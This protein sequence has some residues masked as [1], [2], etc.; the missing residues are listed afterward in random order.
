MLAD[1]SEMRLPQP[2]RGI[3][4][5]DI[6]SRAKRKMTQDDPVLKFVVA[7]PSR[8]IDEQTCGNDAEKNPLMFSLRTKLSILRAL[9]LKKKSPYYIQFYVNGVCN[10]KCR[11]CN[12]VETNSGIGP[13]SL[14]EIET[15]TGGEPF[16]HKQI[17]KI[18]EIFVKHKLEVR[19]QTAGIATS[20]QLQNCYDAGARDLNVSLDS[21]DPNKQDYINSVPGSWEK[22]ID[23][24]ARVSKIF[25]E[26]SAICSLGCVLSRF[27]YREIPAIIE[28]ATRIGW[29]VSLVP[30]HITRTS[31]PMGFRSYDEDFV[32]RESD[33]PELEK[34]F[35]TLSR[36]KRDGYLLFDAERF[37]ESS[38]HFIRTG[39]P[40][41]RHRGVCDSP[42]LYFAIR[43]NGEFAPC[44][45]YTL[46]K[47]PRLSDPDFFRYYRRGDIHKLADPYVKNCAGC[48]YGS[49]PEVSISVRDRKAL[50]HRAK[51]V[52]SS[53]KQIILSSSKE[54]YLAI[55]RDIKRKYPDAY[56]PASEQA[57]IH[58]KLRGWQAPESRRRLLQ[59]DKQRRLIE[60]RT[61]RSQ[62]PE[63]T[64][65][66]SQ[67]RAVGS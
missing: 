39:R 43:P 19:L 10:L 67:S 30:V 17:D 21:L 65:T 52:F 54:E 56:R 3:P 63:R 48:H 4:Y 15:V 16:L 47:P 13:M 34:V 64:E 2:V 23:A 37:L 44:C 24:I 50:W 53:R 55:I 45:D 1:T 29:Y 14:E 58:D 28:F 40:T 62:Q 49:Y 41:W 31:T 46:D 11:Q 33:Y 59:E 26:H 9:L 12:I 18:V 6:S 36:M 27:N 32:F 66:T 7:L 57:E 25:K 60:G 20:E 5:R 61:R 42:D 51:L 38:L 8:R 22:A 35:H